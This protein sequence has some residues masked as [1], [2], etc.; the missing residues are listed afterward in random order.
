MSNEKKTKK[1]DLILDADELVEA[2]KTRED[3]DNWVK[4]LCEQFKN[5]E[6]YECSPE[7]CDECILKD[8]DNMMKFVLSLKMNKNV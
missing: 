6:N 5:N 3:A 4:S 8:F 1:E 7:L 2:L